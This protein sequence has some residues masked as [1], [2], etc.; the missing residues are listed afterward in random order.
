MAEAEAVEEGELPEEDDK[1]LEDKLEDESEERRKEASHEVSVAMTALVGEG[2]S[3]T[4]SIEF[5][6]QNFPSA[7]RARRPERATDPEES[8]EDDDKGKNEKKKNT[9]AV[10]DT[11]KEAVEDKDGEKDKAEKKKMSNLQKFLVFI[12]AATTLGPELNALFETLFRLHKGGSVD[13]LVKDAGTRAKLIA[14]AKA[15]EDE[16]DEKYWDD[17][18]AFVERQK[19]TI[20]DIVYF[21][22]YTMLF[23]S[24][25]KADPFAW[26]SWSDESS[27]V[28]ELV[29]TYQ[30]DESKADLIKTLP[31]IQYDDESVPRYIQASLGQQ[32]FAR[33]LQDSKT[34]KP[35]EVEPG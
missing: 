17:F 15:L 16:S 14:L 31:T 27:K 19:A 6:T 26:H 25:D 8:A 2:R 24:L 3:I 32:A 1:D 33:A 35:D 10:T 29:E 28:D 7:E 18:A 30:K 12:T 22:Q 21:M 5:R 34:E 4:I 13:D 11:L 23:S 20:A 9:K